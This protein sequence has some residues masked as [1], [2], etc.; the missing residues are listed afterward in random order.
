MGAEL[1]SQIGGLL[2][3]RAFA[4]FRQ[5]VDYA[6]RGGAPLLGLDRLAVVGHGRSSP[7]A[8][9]SGIAT[10]AR[11]ADQRITER[12]AEALLQGQRAEGR[13]QREV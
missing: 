4:R 11:L 7:Q 3:R 9:E 13:G 1:V 6:E 8:V 12:L 10:A 2:T 5:R